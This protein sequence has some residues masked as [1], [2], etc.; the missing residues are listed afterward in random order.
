MTVMQ[1]RPP[2]PFKIAWPDE[3]VGAWYR[4]TAE[5]QKAKGSWGKGDLFEQTRQQLLTMAS[6]PEGVTRLAG[7]LDKR[8][9]ARALTALWIE[10]EAFR[11]KTFT[12]A[13][14]EKLVAGQRSNLTRL[15]LS[16]LCALF[17]GWFDRL[18]MPLLEQLGHVITQQCQRF[19]G[20]G[21]EQFSD[22]WQVA[23]MY[24]WLFSTNGPRHLIDRVRQHGGELENSFRRFG[25][26][27]YDRGRFGDLCRAIYYLDELRELP[28]GQWHSVMDELLKESVHKAPYTDDKLIGH[29]ALEIIIDRVQGDPPE[30]WR[31]FVLAIA[32][33]PRISSRSGAYRTWWE[34][35]GKQRIDKVRS[36]LSKLDLGLFLSAVEEYGKY[37]HNS[38]LQRMFPARKKFLEGLLDLGVI[39]S[40]RLMLG[41]NAAAKIRHLLD[42][43]INISY[44]TPI[45]GNMN[46]KAVLYI[47]CT[48]F[49]LIEG[50]HSFKLWVYLAQPNP[51]LLSYDNRYF[52]HSELTTDTL[53]TYQ[54]LHPDLDYIAITHNGW[55]Q[56]KAFEFLA[57]NGIDL[58]IEKLLSKQDYRIY[59]QRFGRP[60]ARSRPNSWRT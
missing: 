53:R 34:I 49:H 20:V 31:Q 41:S 55:W 54:K 7:M 8:V 16:N 50:S 19:P 1:L 27:G 6:Q 9:A 46:D 51:E 45:G 37:S 43:N 3:T 35:L 4:V 21:N 33:D 17:L 30:S 39:R 13:V 42:T 44:A 52:T 18:T 58:D 60:V 57:D 28:V 5:A 40:T 14:L 56:N 38:E 10:E 15:T 47:D 12:A 23:K 26:T 36:W 11:Q 24:P 59:L 2:P 22:I 25:L 32:G 29:A 48:N